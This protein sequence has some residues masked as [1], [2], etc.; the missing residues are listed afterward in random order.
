LT[1]KE[2]SNSIENPEPALK[3]GNYK[4]PSDAE[5]ELISHFGNYDNFDILEGKISDRLSIEIAN[6]KEAT[7]VIVY[8]H[9]L[10]R[11]RTMGQLPYWILIDGIRV[12]VVLFALP[13][14][15][16]P[17]EGHPP[18]NVLE[19]ARMW[20][21]PSV[22]GGVVVDTSG[23][24][25]APS[26]ASSAIGRCLRSA[27]QDWAIKYPKLPDIRCIVSWADTVHHEGTVYKAANF[28]ESGKSGGSMHGSRKRSNG[29]RDQS[30]ADYL[31]IKTRFI[32]DYSSQL[33]DRYL[34]QLKNDKQ[35]EQLQLPIK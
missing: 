29:G 9:Y 2:N 6:L 21:H 17:I 22:Q 23:K 12:G 10:H 24:K 16:V 32:Y 1:I 31:N 34:E 13:R 25:H 14:L 33:N 15:S 27:R 19:L 18:M 26:I 30:N 3:W 8:H 28:R 5:I 11:G 35:D 20:I 7:H 4:T